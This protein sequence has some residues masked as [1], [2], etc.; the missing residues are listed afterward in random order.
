MKGIYASAALG[1]MALVAFAVFGE[2]TF[3]HLAWLASVVVL[4]TSFVMHLPTPRL[5]VSRFA[6]PHAGLL[7]LLLGIAI[8]A[9]SVSTFADLPLNVDG[10]CASVG[11]EARALLNDATP[12]LFGFRWAGM[13]VLG[14][15]PP[16]LSLRF[17]G[18]NL[19]G[20][21]TSG[22][23]EGVL[24]VVGLYFLGRTLFSP[25]V[26]LIGAACC[27]WPPWRT[28]PPAARRPTSTRSS[29]WLLPCCSSSWDGSARAA[30]PWCLAAFSAP[31]ICRCI[32]PVGC[33]P[34][35]FWPSSSSWGCQIARNSVS[36]F[37]CWGSG[38]LQAPSPSVPCSWSSPPTSSLP[39]LAHARCSSSIRTCSL[40]CA[41]CIT[42]IVL[43]RSFLRTPGARCCFSIST[44]TPLLNSA[45]GILCWT[46]SRAASLPWVSGSRP[47]ER[48]VSGRTLLIL[49]T[50]LGVV[51]GAVLT[52]NSP[53]WPRLIVLLP[54]VALLA[55]LALD[56][57]LSWFDAWRPR[58]LRS[59]H[60]LAIAAAIALVMW[61]GVRNWTVYIESKGTYAEGRARIARFLE[62][63]PAGTDAYLVTAGDWSIKD[64]IFEFMVPGVFEGQ[65]APDQVNS[66]IPKL[67]HKA[68]L[69]LTAEQAA[70]V[71]SLEQRFPEGATRVGGGNS[72][73][74]VVFYAFQFP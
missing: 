35:F 58:T 19:V 64:R 41:A 4:L 67:G 50:V 24:S 28:P 48:A 71:S 26:G 13:P 59:S 56:A 20:L 61:I 22:A 30:G 14:Y 47:F 12:K 52:N 6:W 70:L 63:Q 15:L 45:F 62:D 69:I 7:L 74:E 57:G 68:L 29:S 23:V 46:Q 51:S 2:N 9:R 73:N 1:A 38:C 60:A 43:S 33:W 3:V 72:P 65:L 18:N 25:R 32:S 42:W 37:P 17:V 27:S 49:W 36:A 8:L 5:S 55:A 31:S 54:P 53:F 34:L 39:F 40:T 66:E 11:L 16:W 44:R 10:D 21:N